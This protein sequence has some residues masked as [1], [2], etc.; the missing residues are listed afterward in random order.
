MRRIALLSFALL[1]LPLAAH[2]DDIKPLAEW[3]QL[4]PGGTLETR[5]VM[6]GT[7]CPASMRQRAAAAA[8]FP[9][10]C[11]ASAAAPKIDAERIL[12]LGDTGCRIK[13]TLVQACNDPVAWPFASLA[14]A[15]AKLKPD[16]VVHVGDYLYRESPCPAGNAGCAGTPWGNNWP[17]WKADFFD[18]AAPLLATA[19]WVIVR[20]NHEDCYRSGPG[21][22]RLLGPVAYDPNAPCTDHLAPYDIPLGALNL[23]VM[24]TA[25]AQ[26]TS[27]D[28]S[29]TPVYQSE[30]AALANEK[31]PSWL[32]MHRPIWGAVSGPLGM[33]VG[34][35]QT[36]IAA[37]GGQSIPKPVELML[38]GHI[39]VFEALNYNGM[40]PPAMLSGNGGDLLDT[41]P[42]NLKPT[43]FGS[44][45]RVKEGL[46]V[47]G[48]GF[49][50]MTKVRE[51]WN[52]DLYDSTGTFTRRCIFAAGRIDCP[53]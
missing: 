41:V 6:D 28:P 19:P 44:K 3:R 22:L 35:N 8:D 2:A 5:A 33:P 49:F 14:A 48:F 29:V 47:P 46:S 50:L 39:H 21:F 45:V 31:S 24:D 16:L 15:A 17:T 9:L 51:A 27:I 43:V 30:F 42:A 52:V 12:V 53:N 36:M 32:L 40:E 1:L 34:G 18:P 4:G 23:V 26:D 7:A 38:A 10:V 13:D 11:A 37:L 25:N 20:G